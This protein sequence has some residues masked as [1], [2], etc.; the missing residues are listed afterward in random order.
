MHCKYHC[1]KLSSEI[2]EVS[3]PLFNFMSIPF[4]DKTVAFEYVKSLMLIKAYLGV[5]PR[6][7]MCKRYILSILVV[8]NTACGRRV[9][10]R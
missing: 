1:L 7:C 8:D 9:A 5:L 4:F 3:K 6:L 2:S 10:A